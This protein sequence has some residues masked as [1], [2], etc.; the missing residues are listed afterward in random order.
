[1]LETVT[2]QDPTSMTLS[3][4]SQSSSKSICD[5]SSSLYRSLAPHL[6]S[7]CH[8]VFTL[9]AAAVVA[10]QDKDTCQTEMLHDFINEKFLI[11]IPNIL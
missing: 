2:V 4:V 10:C 5:L 3:K 6:L 11:M 1:M 9:V 8:L 7:V